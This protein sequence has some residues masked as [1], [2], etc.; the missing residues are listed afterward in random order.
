MTFE[1]WLIFLLVMVPRL[2]FGDWWTGDG[3][4]SVSFPVL[5][6]FV[7]SPWISIAELSTRQ[8]DLGFHRALSPVEPEDWHR[9][10]ALFPSLPDSADVVS[11]PYSPS[12]G[13]SVKSCYHKLLVGPVVSGFHGV[14]KARI[15]LKIKIFMWQAI[16]GRLP[17][18]D[19]IKKRNGPGSEFCVLCGLA[20]NIEHILFRCPLA[21]L[22]WSYLREW[23][24]VTWAPN[25]FGE[26]RTL[27]SPLVGQIKRLFWFG[28]SAMC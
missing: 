1:R 17:A 28:F 21:K 26:L 24:G 22:F 19:Q 18:A 8:W 4:L 15:P 6:S 2:V 14:W 25:S 10:A 13:F 11:W 20:E 7:A 27:V 3:P 16:R 5:F 9:L 23:L 12:G